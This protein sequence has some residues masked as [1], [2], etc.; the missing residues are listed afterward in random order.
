M[1]DEDTSEHNWQ[2]GA[3]VKLMTSTDG[4]NWSGKKTIFPVLSSWPG[5]LTL[6]PTTVLAMADNG[7]S[8]FTVVD[9]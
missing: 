8:K 3:A 7:G 1:T 4:V 2:Q 9:V 5:L 6:N